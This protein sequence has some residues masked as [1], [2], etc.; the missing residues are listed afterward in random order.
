M[1]IPRGHAAAVVQN[2]EAHGRLPQAVKQAVLQDISMRCGDEGG[3]AQH[4]C[5]LFT[6]SKPFRP[7]VLLRQ[8]LLR[9]RCTRWHGCLYCTSTSIK[10]RKLYKF[11]IVL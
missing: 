1:P 7:L 4:L 5:G 11:G 3:L 10:L 2:E 9:L 6:H 8:E